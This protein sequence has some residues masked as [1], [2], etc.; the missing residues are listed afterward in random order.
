MKE[1]AVQLK[2]KV[3]HPFSEEDLEILKEYKQHQILKCRLQGVQK[4]RSY[5]QLKLYW[6]AARIVANN[7][8]NKQWNTKDKVDF[9][10]RVKLH[11]A[12]PDTVVVKPDGTIAYK[13]RSI[14]FKNLSHIMACNYFDRAFEVMAKFLGIT[15]EKLIEEVKSQ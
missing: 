2:D 9:Q 12:D 6:S 10:C 7:T 11:F 5:L 15:S 13:Y 4:P 8:D 14:A 3:L 1:I